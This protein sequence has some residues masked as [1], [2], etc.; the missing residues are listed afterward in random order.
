MSKSRPTSPEKKYNLGV[1]CVHDEFKIVKEGNIRILVH[2]LQNGLNVNVVRWS[3]WTLLHRA[4]EAGHTD[5]CELLLSQGARLEQ[6]TTMGWLTPLHCAIGNGYKETAFML[7]EKGAD[8]RSK[9]KDGLT[10]FQYASKRGF[11]RLSDDFFDKVKKYEEIKENIRRDKKFAD[12]AAERLAK[13][14]KSD[15]NLSI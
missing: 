3:G 15:E 10:S 9:N 11:T 13:S 1:D 12:M 6:R 5:I 4:C 7:V 8:P 2:L 14:S